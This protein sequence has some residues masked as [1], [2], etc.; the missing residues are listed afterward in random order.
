M[1][2]LYEGDIFKSFQIFLI[3]RRVDTKGTYLESANAPADCLQRPRV[4]KG[5]WCQQS[6]KPA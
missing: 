3:N 6:L 2:P 5:C 4:H 1:M